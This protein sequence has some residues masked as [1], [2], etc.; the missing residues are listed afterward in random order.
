MTNENNDDDKETPKH[1]QY[2]VPPKKTI[3]DADGELWGHD[4]YP[5]RRG[6]KP[7]SIINT[8]LMKEGRENLTKIRCERM[9]HNCVLKRKF[10][11]IN[12]NIIIKMFLVHI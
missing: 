8:I 2:H 9:V 1:S 7:R 6:T 12:M 11:Q 10:Y 4:L 5:E 3:P